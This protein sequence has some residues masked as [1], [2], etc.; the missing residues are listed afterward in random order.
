MERQLAH[1]ARY[2]SLTQIPNRGLFH[3]CLDQALFRA[4]SSGSP[5]ALLYMDLDSFKEINDTLGHAAGDIVLRHAVERLVMVVREEDTV[6]R[7]GGD[8]FTV[9]MTGFS[10]REDVVATVERIFSTLSG[11]LMAGGQEV[12][13]TASVGVAVFPEDGEEGGTGSSET[14]TSLCTSPRNDGGMSWSSFVPN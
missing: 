3:D 14:P 13:V 9:I 10:G 8:E 4:K 5:L 7:M 12:S 11:P 2:D 1:Q 6:A